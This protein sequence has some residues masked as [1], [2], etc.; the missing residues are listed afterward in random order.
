[1]AT[2]G[3]LALRDGFDEPTFALIE[4]W[5]DGNWQPFSEA[6][7][8]V[9]FDLTMLDSGRFA[10]YTVLTV[11]AVVPEPTAFAVVALAI[12]GI[13][14]GRPNAIDAPVPAPQPRN[15]NDR[16]THSPRPT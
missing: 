7:P 4:F 11:G 5:S 13:A 6:I 16:G 10:G 8:G 3:M 9:D 12:A 2:G 14:L 15:W 1:M